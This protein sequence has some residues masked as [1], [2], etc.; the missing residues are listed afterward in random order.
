MI[1]PPLKQLIALLALVLVGAASP[2]HLERRAGP[3]GSLIEPTGTNVYSASTGDLHVSY[4][5]VFLE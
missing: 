3:S 2:L 4:K 5:G 1:S